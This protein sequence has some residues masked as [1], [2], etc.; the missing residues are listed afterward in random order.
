MAIIAKAQLSPTVSLG[1]AA[2]A[3]S[4]AMATATAAATLVFGDRLGMAWAGVPAMFGIVGTAAGSVGV[5]RLVSAWG[6]RLGLGG[7]YLLGAAGIALAAIVTLGGVGALGAAIAVAVGMLLL[8]AGNA[9]AQLSRY[10]AAERHAPDRRG[11]AIALVVWITTVG[12]VGGPLLLG[13]ATRIA[14]EGAFVLAACCAGLAAIVVATVRG[15]D[16]PKP[17]ATTPAR[18]FTAPITRRAFAAM[19]TA[20]VVMVAVM[21]ATPMAL[22]AHGS[23]TMTIGAVLSAHTLGMF[24][25]SPVTGLLVDRWGPLKVVWAGFA[26]LAL[27]SAGTTLSAGGSQA[28]ALFLLGLGW[29]LC[30]IAG[31]GVLAA[32]LPAAGKLRVE[33]KVEAAVWTMA[34]VAALLSTVLLSAGGAVM[35]AVVATVLVAIAT[36]V[37]RVGVR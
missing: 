29:N 17:V 18:L 33:A 15:S 6:P 11:S 16:R 31:S 9:A 23:S 3:M 32:G 35:L 14:A 36:L 30:F 27:A 21:T 37:V 2:A 34:A 22:H 10:V 7:G 25:A 26:V 1:V 12:A 5:A 13:P 8:G 20:Q 19:A 4:A 24:G 28:I